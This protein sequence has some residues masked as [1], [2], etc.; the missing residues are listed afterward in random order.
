[1]PQSGVIVGALLAA[2]IVYLAIKGRLGVYYNLLIGGAGTQPAG[3]A[4]TSTASPNVGPSY[5]PSGNIFGTSRTPLYLP[6]WLGGGA[7]PGTYSTF[8]NPAPGMSPQTQSGNPSATPGPPIP[9]GQTY[10]VSP[11]GAGTGGGN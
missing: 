11:G 9:P 1:M 2:F 8:G 5:G 3:M 7:I 10:V 4:P 6:S